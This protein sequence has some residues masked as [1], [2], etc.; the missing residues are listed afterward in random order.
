M[1]SGAP[2]NFEAEW[3]EYLGELNAAGLE[4]WIARYQAYYDE[5]IK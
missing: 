3:E 5:N 1:I 2:E 4:N